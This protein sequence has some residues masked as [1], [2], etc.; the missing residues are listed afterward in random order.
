VAKSLLLTDGLVSERQVRAAVAKLQGSAEA[1][2]AAGGRQ[3]DAAQSDTSGSSGAASEPGG[4]L[5]LVGSGGGEV[6]G[7]A[8]YGSSAGAGPSG[9]QGVAPS[10]RPIYVSV[11]HR[12]S[13]DVAVAIVR[14]LCRHRIPEPI[15][16]ADLLSRERVR[17]M[18]S[19]REEGG[20]Q[21]QDGPR[22]QVT[23]SGHE[24]CVTEK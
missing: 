12:I 3:R 17:Q 22:A 9:R 8:V 21:Q 20:E 13:L 6:L 19:Q 7:A 2:A 14:R 5:P 11:G 23:D 24:G 16:Q 10:S 1:A 4:W 18:R 15:R